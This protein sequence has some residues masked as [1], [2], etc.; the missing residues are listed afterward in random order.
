MTD[1]HRYAPSS[2]PVN[3]LA[4]YKLSKRN[5]DSW[6]ILLMWSIIFTY[7][8]VDMIRIPAVAP[9]NIGENFYIDGGTFYFAKSISGV[10]DW[11]SPS[12]LLT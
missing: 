12:K 5:P 9:K 7:H 8:S 3:I 1:S 2:W 10:N 6:N 11:V 4:H